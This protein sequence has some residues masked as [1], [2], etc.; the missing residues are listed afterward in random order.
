MAKRPM[1]LPARAVLHESVK[2]AVMSATPHAMRRS[3]FSLNAN[4]ASSTVKTPSKLSSKDALAARRRGQS[5][6]QQHG[7]ITPPQTMAAVSPRRS[8]RV[9]RA[10]VSLRSFGAMR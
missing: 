9:R 7:P 10:S 4:H 5:D 1:G 2:A 3:K 6:H 8:R